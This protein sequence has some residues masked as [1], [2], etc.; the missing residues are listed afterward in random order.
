MSIVAYTLMIVSTMVHVA[1]AK[2]ASLTSS[3]GQRIIL[4]VVYD[5]I[6][7]SSGVVRHA[8]ATIGPSGVSD[9]S[10]AEASHPHVANVAIEATQ[11]VV[12]SKSTNHEPHTMSPLHI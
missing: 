12:M 7:T 9:S 6:I 3:S 11:P 10:C 5:T 1:H 4:R 2:C 8:T